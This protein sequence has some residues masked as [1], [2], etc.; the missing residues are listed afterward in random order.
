LNYCRFEATEGHPVLP[1]CPEIVRSDLI[2]GPDPKPL[3]E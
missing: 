3:R 1:E 2:R